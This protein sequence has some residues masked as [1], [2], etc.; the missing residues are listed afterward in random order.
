MK[1]KKE[2]EREK[3][4]NKEIQGCTF[5][6]QLTNLPKYNQK[7]KIPNRE[8]IGEEN[9]YNKMKRARQISQEKNKGDELVERYDE[10]RKKKENL[11]NKNLTFGSFFLENKNASDGSINRLNINSS[12]HNW[13][14]NSYPLNKNNSI[15]DGENNIFDFTLNKQ[16]ND[17]NDSGNNNNQKINNNY[18]YN[19]N[20]HNNYIG[21]NNN[22][23]FN[24]N[25]NNNFILDKNPNNKNNNNNYTMQN[26]NQLN[27]KNNKNNQ[28]VLG[29][30]YLNYIDNNK[31]NNKRNIKSLNNNNFNFINLSSESSGK[32][33]NNVN[34]KNIF[35]EPKINSNAKYSNQRDN[36]YDFDN[37]LT[38][39][40]FINKIHL[41]AL[42][43]ILNPSFYNDDQEKEKENNN[44]SSAS[45]TKA[46]SILSVQKKV[47]IPC[48]IGQ[49]IGSLIIQ[50]LI[51]IKMFSANIIILIKMMIIIDKKKC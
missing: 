31:F 33:Y 11:P 8:L 42:N 3:K 29:L 32:Q 39:E 7:S 43:N 16:L 44:V 48:R 30:N 10:R 46:N 24:N 45:V 2:N 13:K 51:K 25:I 18:I 1:K 5:N 23:I 14:I 36:I 41:N 34:K 21:L 17:I 49:K 26:N 20:I 27:I 4:I 35:N 15:N 6:P 9:Y 50:K 38:E 47:H 28:K 12:I 22:N 19:N 40:K 37:N